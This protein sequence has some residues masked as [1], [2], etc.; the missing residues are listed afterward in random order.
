MAQACKTK[1]GRQ[2]VG[3]LGHL[4]RDPATFTTYPRISSGPK[5]C[6][7]LHYIQCRLRRSSE[8]NPGSTSRLHCSPTSVKRHLLLSLRQL[9]C[10][11]HGT[12]LLACQIN[13]PRTLLFAPFVPFIVIFCHVME[14]RDHTDSVRLDAFVSSIHAATDVSEPAAKMYR[15]FQV[16]NKIAARYIEV[17]LHNN[18]GAPSASSMDAQ[19]AALG[20]P[21]AGIYQAQNEMHSG[22]GA[23][24]PDQQSLDP[25]LWMGDN[26]QLEDWFYNNQASMEL[27]QDA[28]LTCT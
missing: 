10:Y 24:L 25:V 28:D 26:M 11:P 4:R 3:L 9:V 17:G 18:S 27:L 15:L 6:A 7:V 14:T 1:V 16:L 19:L 23:T 13:T 2:L 8:S 21:R 22:I 12:G 20:F 5:R